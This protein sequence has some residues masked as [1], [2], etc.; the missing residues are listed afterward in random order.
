ME[1]TRSAA[2]EVLA[3]HTKNENLRKH[4]LAVEA[5]VRTYAR[6]LG[7]DEEK[8]GITALLHDFDY[9]RYPDLADHPFRG[10]EILRERGWPE[11]IIRAILSHGDHTGV[12]RE[13]LM[14]RVLFAC[15]ELT[16]LITAAALI[17]PDK[18]LLNLQV[19]SIK[20]RM[21]EKAFARTVKRED[22]IRGADEL[23]V[24]LDEHIAIVL[25]AMCGIASELGL[26]GI[27]A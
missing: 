9:E 16:G 20:K 17:R 7:E 27:S 15:D 13:S 11:E 23:G 1:F 25:D 4:A 5:A 18:N 2:W 3:E 14:E 12:S 21:K 8:W 24:D 22:I 19:T 10:A 26:T 6:K